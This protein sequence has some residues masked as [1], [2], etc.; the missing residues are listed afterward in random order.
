MTINSKSSNT[1]FA[2]QQGRYQDGR[3]N[4]SF[5]SEEWLESSLA[6]KE[7]G[8]ERIGEK[9]NFKKI[10]LLGLVIFF[11]M[12][13][14]FFRIFLLE[15]IDGDK[16]HLMAQENRVRLSLVE[17]KRGIIYDRNGKPLVRNV[18]SFNLYLVP[19]DLPP[20]Q[21]QKK[22]II[23]EIKNILGDFNV[24][25]FEKELEKIKPGSLVSF[26]PRLIAGNISYEKAMLLYLKSNLWP[27]VTLSNTTRR[28]YEKFMPTPEIR[29]TPNPS[30]ALGSL[31]RGTETNY[32]SSSPMIILSAT[33]TE[34]LLSFSH[35]LGYTGKISEDELKKY[36]SGY[37]PIDYVGK[38]GLEYFYE[39]ELKGVK[40]TKEIEVDA[41]GKEKRIINETA[42]EDGKNLVLSIDASL[43]NKVEETLRSYLTKLK[44][45]RAVAV[46]M[47]PQNGEI[48]ALV[49]LPSFDNNAFARGINQKEYQAL[50]NNPDQ[51]LFNRAISGQYPS[52][53]TVKMVMAAAA[54]QEGVIDENTK[55][56]STGGIR[57]NQWF[58]PDWK[59]GG[60]GIV[61]VETAL[62]QSVNTFF[63]YIGGGYND[64]VGLGVDRISEYLKLFD[65][66]SPSGIDLP[67]EAGGFI[68]TRDWKKSVKGEDW[69]VG[70]TYH[71]AIGQGDLLVTPLQVAWYTSVFA[72]SGALYRPHVVE[73]ITTSSP[74]Q[75][76]LTPTF[77]AL[78][79]NLTPP[80]PNQE[81]AKD[82]KNYLIKKDFIKPENIEIVRKGLRLAVTDGSARKLNDLPF[83][84]AGKTGT[85]Q[86]SGG[87]DPHA[88][89]TG[90]APYDNPQI[91][92]T[93]L[94]E[95][96]NEGSDVAVP[97][98]KE[99]LAWAMKEGVLTK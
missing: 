41:R 76:F 12:G 50:L 85:A 5:A 43:Q 60:H 13:L 67:G 95:A 7:S 45:T 4:R 64:F 86:E 22:E 48:L 61:N 2:I 62:A 16:Y 21:N 89:F 32:S 42:P 31:E 53:S 96:G 46:A 33:S 73:D 15:V 23:N 70:N 93:I 55:V 18:A 78:P 10:F 34:P 40:G 94:V 71:L 56:L 69:Y 72:N 74:V 9:F 8:E 65:L 6:P 83:T 98:A 63:Y 3:L 54:L 52:G 58:F 82:G 90:F 14:I 27:G 79:T 26:Q 57:V 30:P 17:A 28:E 1:L 81:R 51:P 80:S 75:T 68:P 92:L 47:N 38:T 97:A 35:I 91:V 29:L 87:K 37:S 59:A 99:I 11:F 88:W 25:A 84:M 20:D 77:P 66:G 36:S 49:S 44:L 39:P 24:E 19:A